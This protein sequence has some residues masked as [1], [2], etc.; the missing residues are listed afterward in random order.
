MKRQSVT[1]W[2]Y[3]A[4]FA[5]HLIGFLISNFR[6]NLQD[7]VWYGFLGLLWFHFANDER[8]AE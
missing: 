6:D 2:I 5:L 1:Y 7:M 3:T 4:I 8:A